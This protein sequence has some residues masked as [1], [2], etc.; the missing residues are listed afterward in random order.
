LA[1]ASSEI[2]TTKTRPP[3]RT[4]QEEKSDAWRFVP[5]LPFEL[6]ACPHQWFQ[7]LRLPVVSYALPALIAIGHVRHA[8]RPTSNPIARAVRNMAKRRTLRVLGQI[9]PTGGGFLEATPLTSFVVMSLV[10]S[11]QSDH[12]VTKNGIDFLVRSVRPDGSWPIDTNLST[13][14]TTL[15]VNALA[16]HPE[17]DRILPQDDRLKLREWIL[18][19]H[20]RVEHPYTHAAPG[21]WAWTNLPGGVPDAD[22]TAGA[23]LALWNLGFRDDKTLDAVNAAVN[24]LL[25]LQNRD[26]GIPTFCRGWGNLPFDRSGSDLTAHALHA[27]AI[28]RSSLSPEVQIKI[29]KAAKRGLAYLHKQQR[30][31]G[32]WT[33]LWFGNQ[34]APDDEN[35]TYGTSRVLTAL[36]AMKQTPSCDTVVD[37][38]INRGARWLLTSQ[39]ADGGW[40]GAM[41]SPPSIEETALAVVA[42]AT[43]ARIMPELCEA[44][45]VPHDVGGRTSS[46]AVDRERS[47]TFGQFST[48]DGPVGSASRTVSPT[49]QEMVRDADSTL[50]EKSLGARGCGRPP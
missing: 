5:Q 50:L 16:A 25:D 1:D 39:N 18:G 17:F 38:M 22:D 44:G 19:Q 32:A 20:N 27:W 3:R 48:T 42:L 4:L 8:N 24:W 36:C 41:K 26:G 29:D 46:S 30:A 15:S 28:W 33:P 23:L 10:G 47:E 6:A 12:A 34:F 43:V 11:G 14:V 37:S 7:G 35:P 13:W 2:A 21:A 45:P 40:G 31:D 49:G 9:Q